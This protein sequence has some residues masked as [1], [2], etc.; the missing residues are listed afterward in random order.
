MYTLVRN[1]LLFHKGFDQLSTDTPTTELRSNLNVIQMILIAENCVP[2]MTNFIQ[3][4]TVVRYDPTA[5]FAAGCLAATF[6]TEIEF[7]RNYS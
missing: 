2:K 3:K 4:T 7:H 1:P 5:K 6:E